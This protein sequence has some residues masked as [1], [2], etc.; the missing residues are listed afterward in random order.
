MCMKGN[1]NGVTKH[2][3]TYHKDVLRRFLEEK[4]ESAANSRAAG[5]AV[6][7]LT[8]RTPTDA[9]TISADQ[10]KHFDELAAKWLATSHCPFDLVEDQGFR[11]VVQFIATDLG[12]VTANVPDRRTVVAEVGASVARLQP[13]LKLKVR[14][15]C[16]HYSL[17]SETWTS[18]VKRSY[19]A[20]RL[21]FLDKEFKQHQMTLEVKKLPSKCSTEAIAT[22]L[23][24]VMGQWGLNKAKCVRLVGE[25]AATTVAVAKQLS[26]PHGFCV[27]QALHLAVSGAL[28]RKEG[29]ASIAAATST[30]CA[31]VG[32]RAD[33][34]E[35]AGEETDFVDDDDAYGGDLAYSMEVLRNEAHEEVDR[36]MVQSL[37]AEDQEALNVIR[38]TVQTFRDLVIFFTKSP[39]AK[40]RFAQICD[41][42]QYS[43]KLALRLDCPT[44]WSTSYDMLM[45]LERLRNSVDGF[46]EFLSTPQGQEAFGHIQLTQ[47]SPEQ[48]LTIKCLRALLYSLTRM[49]EMMGQRKCLLLSDGLLFRRGIRRLLEKEEVF[50][51]EVGQVAGAYVQPVLKRMHRM[52]R[53]IL[54]MFLVQSPEP[55]KELRWVSYLDPRSARLALYTPEDVAEARAFVIATIVEAAREAVPNRSTTP[56]EQPSTESNYEITRRFLSRLYGASMYI[57]PEEGETPE[58]TKE[59]YEGQ[60]Q[61]Y[62]RLAEIVSHD[63][64]PFEWWR[65]HA[66]LYPALAKLARKWLSS[67]V[68]AVP[69]DRAFTTSGSVLTAK[70]YALAPATVRDCVFVADNGWHR[71]LERRT[72]GDGRYK[73]EGGAVA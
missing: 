3:E 56:Q 69:N 13:S 22:A 2:M 9:T 1:T 32:S 4:E 23:A 39:S 31:A 57:E 8:M 38:D 24:E 12:G 52:R 49:A 61:S 21:H 40:R 10:Q 41:E 42:V 19:M 30:A 44:R 20:V 64:D 43:F 59:R 28:M 68:T 27:A 48:W 66:S 62:L 25:D 11:D 73:L 70:R 63:D 29:A 53:A 15:S 7:D 47:P 18:S 46:F 50:D 17:T 58:A 65:G 26:V 45:R 51:C 14:E 72:S 16:D 54:R 35:H 67:M 60:L 34:P 71:S 55:G 33:E 6:V 36:C 5:G 37:S